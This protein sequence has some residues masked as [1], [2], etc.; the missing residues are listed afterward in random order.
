M[1]PLLP[2]KNLNI[3]SSVIQL[4]EDGKIVPD[5]I[6]TFNV[7]FANPVINDYSLD[8]SE[9]DF[10]NHSSVMSIKRHKYNI[11]FR[12]KLVNN[13]YVAD[14]LKNLNVKK[15][16]GLDGIAPKLLKNSVIAIADP[17]TELFNYCLESCRWP[18]EWK[19]SEK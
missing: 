1:K 7:Y 10:E 15:S 9:R 11:D 8:L 14:L 13:T 17:L 6:S 2:T 12:F 19:Q 18:S 4:V 16:C 5:P 3:D